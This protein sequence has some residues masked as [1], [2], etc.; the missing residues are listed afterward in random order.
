MIVITHICGWIPSVKLYCWF[1]E[2]RKFLLYQ[3]IRCNNFRM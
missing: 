1:T 2:C 3:K